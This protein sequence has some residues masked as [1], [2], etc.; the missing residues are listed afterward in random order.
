MA[1][2]RD[3]GAEFA[4]ENPGLA[5]YLMRGSQDP[6]V[7]RL[8]EGFAFLTGRLRE[9]LDSEL[10]EL[11][12]GLLELLWPQMLR[13]I[14]CTSI[15]CFEARA[16]TGF[17][18]E[19]IPAGTQ[20]QS[21]PI[22]DVPFI[23]R[24][25]HDLML[26]PVRLVA[27]TLSD[28]AGRSVLKIGLSVPG[29]M[30]AESLD[31]DPLRLFLNFGWDRNVASDLRLMLLRHVRSFS[32]LCEDGRTIALGANCIRPVGF[33]PSE[34]V[35]P[36][37][38]S[39]FDGFRLLQEYLMI[40]DKFMFIDVVGLPPGQ[41]LG[42]SFTLIF[43]FEHVVPTGIRL[44]PDQLQANCTPVINL[45]EIDAEPIT[46]HRRRSEYRL[47][48]PS[49]R[50]VQRRLYQILEI[51]GWQR[52]SAR[53]VEYLP[54][55]QF[56]VLNSDQMAGYYRLRFQPGL[57]EGAEAYL[58]FVDRNDR[59]IPAGAETIVASVLA[60]DGSGPEALGVNMIDQPT[61]DSP[62]F[63]N[64]RNL[65]PPTPFVNAPI[66][67]QGFW[68]VVMMLARNYHSLIDLEGLRILLAQLNV[69]AVQD[70][71]AQS[72]QEQMGQA[73]LRV[74]TR[75]MDTLIRGLP[76]RGRRIQLDVNELQLG[77][78]GPAVLFGDTFNAFLRMFATVN[79]CHQFVLRCANRNAVYQWPTQ[80]G[81]T[82]SI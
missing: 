12:H 2:L 34:A 15:V 36:V 35:L 19:K 45:F 68:S 27:A 75:G 20:V 21:R 7:E 48:I 5:P 66:G 57:S 9:R 37:L 46:L 70:R 4:S 38:E 24:T 59:P 11:T 49:G 6:A 25:C 52:G 43:E 30:P 13:P 47:R 67:R 23:F 63:A 72:R 10:P 14:P 22:A 40:P 58:S 18:S 71:D 50:T 32:V 16:D 29:G 65:T 26:R 31:L 78:I 81:S 39:A 3:L 77:G 28:I 33:E 64:F 61:T 62:T 42:A 74:Q 53:R 54:F 56:A 51:A 60:C 73:L 79:S 8:L 82:S 55:E 44:G 69:R 76:V 1:Y 17:K 41:I 80:T